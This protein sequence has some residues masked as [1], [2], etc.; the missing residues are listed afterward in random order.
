MANT[1]DKKFLKSNFMSNFLIAGNLQLLS[2]LTLN[3]QPPL[4]TSSCNPAR[5]KR[6]CAGTKRISS[7]PLSG[8]RKALIPNSLLGSAGY[9]ILSFT[10]GNTMPS[11]NVETPLFRYQKKS[12]T[13]SSSGSAGYLLLSFTTGNTRYSKN[14]ETPLFRFAK[15]SQ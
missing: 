5:F 7:A 14:V 15:R 3:C 11:K 4:P 13:I 6:A 1:T 12:I 9:L 10:T 8:T 2:G